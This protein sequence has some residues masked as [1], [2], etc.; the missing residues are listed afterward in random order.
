MVKD[1]LV[2][3]LD[4]TIHTELSMVSSKQSI[5]INSIVKDAVEKWLQK[6]NANL[7]KHDLILYTDEKSFSNLINDIDK[8]AM[9]NNFSKTFF[10]HESEFGK[11]AKAS[12]WK[13]YSSEQDHQ[14]A[15]HKIA[16]E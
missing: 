10:G 6:N 13:I 1:L 16:K 7:K 12:N 3:G 9:V 14:F 8:L 15:I 2:R 11:I 4:D 5:S